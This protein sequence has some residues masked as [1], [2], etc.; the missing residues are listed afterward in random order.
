MKRMSVL[1]VDNSSGVRRELESVISEHCSFE[2]TISVDSPEAALEVARAISP[3]LV[4]YDLPLSGGSDAGVIRELKASLPHS[5]II[6]ISLYDNYRN[7]ALGAGADEFVS[8]TAPRKVL[9]ETIARLC[10][11]ETPPVNT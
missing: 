8:K 5:R 11:P 4:I 7:A 6:A 3:D 1:L 10:P 9:A 2:V